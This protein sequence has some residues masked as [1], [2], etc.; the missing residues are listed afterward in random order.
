MDEKVDKVNITITISGEVRSGKTLIGKIIKDYLTK[1]GVTT[2]F[3][4]NFSV[5]YL[6]LEKF[7]SNKQHITIVSN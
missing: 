1:L 7:D 6:N 4:E 5:K 2:D 3:V